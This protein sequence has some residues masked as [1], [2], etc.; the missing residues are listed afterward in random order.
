MVTVS[1]N[2]TETPYI[3]CGAPLTAKKD[4]WRSESFWLNEREPWLL[5]KVP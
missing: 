5:N 3:S 2:A 4:L 1:Y